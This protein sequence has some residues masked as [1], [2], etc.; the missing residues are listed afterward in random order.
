MKNL[1]MATF[2][3]AF[4]FTLS[5]PAGA[6]D[7]VGRW[8]IGGSIGQT[9]VDDYC[10]SSAIVTVRNCSDTDTGLA[11]YGGYNLHENFAVEGGYIDFG[12]VTATFRI[13][14]AD[15]INKDELWSLFGAG[16]GKINVGERVTLFGKAGLHRWTADKTLTNAN[17]MG[18]DDDGVDLFYGI[19]GQVSLPGDKFKIRLEYQIFKVGDPYEGEVFSIGGSAYEFVGNSTDVKLLSIGL[20]YTF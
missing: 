5:Q 7:D 10:D 20:T 9:K 3:V 6:Q 2:V 8:Y 14:S 1:F 4:T 12:E 19:G 13:N 17:P 15:A 11:I 16:V 18:F